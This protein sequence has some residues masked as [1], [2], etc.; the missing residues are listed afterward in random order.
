MKPIR[1]NKYLFIIIDYLAASVAW[2]TFFLF[3]KTYIEKS[4]FEFSQT[5]FLGLILIPL[6]WLF[7]YWVVGM[8]DNIL[9]KY[10]LQA[11]YQTFSGSLFGT[12]IIFFIFILDDTVNKY[13]DYYISY[14]FL[15]GSHFLITFLGRYWIIADI[16]K[17]IHARKIGFNTLIIGGNQKALDTYHELNDSAKN[18]A[19][20]FFKGYIKTN[21]KDN[22]LSEVLPELGTI[23]D[24]HLVIQDYKIE[25][26][27]I[28]IETTEHNK[29]QTY[30]NEL[31]GYQ[32]VIKIIPDMFDILS[33]KVKTNNLFGTPLIHIKTDILPYWQKRIKR[34]I[35][36]TFSLSGFVLTLPAFIILPIIIKKGSTGPVFFKQERIGMHGLPFTIYKF[37]TM[38]TNA[39]EQGPQLSSEHD[40]R[41][42]PIG[43]FL[44][45]TRLDEIP[46]FYNVLK[47]DMSFVGPR[48]ERQY[49]I[50]QIMTKAPHYKHLHKVKPGI[51][52][53][54]QVKYGYAENIDQ[55]VE[56]L[57]FDILYVKNQSLA[58]DF[59]ILV[60][61]IIIILKR[62]GK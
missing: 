37:R 23:N 19:G 51:T 44:R 24:L 52:S 28:A 54:G 49:F 57:K 48:P 46:Q 61:T 36:I 45:K 41:I 38:Y 26:I 15:F 27:I 7:S 42:T 17:K 56:R 13:S 4:S 21:G 14:I 31:D 30:L 9:R 33:G 2:G 40:P 5:F 35:D 16:V 3:R 32:L 20:N 55:M 39:E 34:L 53:W 59:K 8:Y 11:L 10:R 50:E 62:K 22:V 47:G 58:L 1:I 43:R 6:L 60:Y 25:E 29:I 18:Y 12:L